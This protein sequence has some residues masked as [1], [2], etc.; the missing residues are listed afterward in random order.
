MRVLIFAAGLGT[1]LKPITDTIPKA[2]VPI[3]GK[4]LLEHLIIKLKNEGFTDFVINIHHFADKIV[5]F[6]KKNDSFDVNI[7]FSDERDL[8]RDTGGGIKHA[9][10]LLN[11]GE[12]FLVHNVDIIS[13]LD[14]NKFYRSQY[15]LNSATFSGAS[16]I[17]LALLLVSNR[18]TDRY[19]LFDNDNNLCAWVNLKTGEFKTPFNDLKWDYESAKETI[20]KNNSN[21][22][23]EDLELFFND[24]G[25]QK[26]AFAGVHSISPMVFPLMLKWPDKFSI[27]DFYLSVA[28]KYDIKAYIDNN[29]N[30]IDVGRIE[31]LKEA[32]ILLQENRKSDD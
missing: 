24:N 30:I 32:E 29:L 15:E 16:S 11:D 14:I 18:D 9:A 26:Y 1:R 22:I 6:V 4:P 21:N 17:P 7:S 3:G 28:D 8:L 5:D 25:L 27:I 19:L 2:L 12:P 23:R 10:R 31:N 20:M 13:N